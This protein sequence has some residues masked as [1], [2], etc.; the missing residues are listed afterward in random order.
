MKKITVPTVLAIISISAMIIWL[1][2][3]MLGNLDSAG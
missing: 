2:T 1:G 3:G